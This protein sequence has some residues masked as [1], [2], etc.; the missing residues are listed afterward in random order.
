[1]IAIY[2]PFVRALLCLYATLCLHHHLSSRVPLDYVTMSVIFEMMIATWRSTIGS[3]VR[4]GF[5]V[6]SIIY[7]S[8]SMTLTTANYF[9]IFVHL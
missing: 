6:S 7:L 3:N 5:S 1:M 8:P 2:S 9:P 4:H